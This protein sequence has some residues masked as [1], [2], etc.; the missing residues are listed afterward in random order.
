MAV[1]YSSLTL[2]LITTPTHSPAAHPSRRPHR[3]DG[4][5]SPVHPVAVPRSCHHPPITE[6][7]FGYRRH[8]CWRVLW[9]FRHGLT[10]Q[11]IAGTELLCRRTPQLGTRWRV[12][13]SG[14]PSSSPG[15][16]SPTP[17]GSGAAVSGTGAPVSGNGVRS[18]MS[19]E[20][21]GFFWRS[22]MS[23]TPV[24][25]AASRSPTA[26]RAHALQHP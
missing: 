8:G 9:L 14:N 3:S 10:S 22:S 21:G 12:G 5:R 17:S 23:R 2:L 15:A 19:P 6:R 18:S 16:I 26:V 11:E 4:S 1:C 7:L 24:D 13:R 25:T 20:L